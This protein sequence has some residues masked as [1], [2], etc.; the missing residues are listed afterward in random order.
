[1][2]ASILYLAILEYGMLQQ[3]QAHRKTWYLAALKIW[4]HMHFK[5]LP[6]LP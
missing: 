1:M 6:L 4:T 5:I 3:N 2:E